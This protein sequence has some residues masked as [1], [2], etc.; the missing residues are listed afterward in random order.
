ML[1]VFVNCKSLGLAIVVFCVKFWLI[2]LIVPLP[3]ILFRSMS[4]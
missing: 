3:E 2:L 1:I 4:M